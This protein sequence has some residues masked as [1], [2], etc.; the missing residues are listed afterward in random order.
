MKYKGAEYLA[1]HPGRWFKPETDEQLAYSLGLM[2]Y[3]RGELPPC[4]Q[5]Y[6]SFKLPELKVPSGVETMVK[7]TPLKLEFFMLRAIPVFLKYNVLVT[8]VGNAI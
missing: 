3:V 7:N 8:E 5:K 4:L 2:E 1:Q 6:K